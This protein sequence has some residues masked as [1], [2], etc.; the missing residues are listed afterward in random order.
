[1]RACQ[2][3]L[4]MLLIVCYRGQMIIMIECHFFNQL[5]LRPVLTFHGVRQRE[6]GHVL[7]PSQLSGSGYTVC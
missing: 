5:F 7:V 4:G 3:Q 6:A 1:M 2:V